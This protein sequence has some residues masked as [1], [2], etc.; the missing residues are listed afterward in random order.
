MVE[1]LR[2][3]AVLAGLAAVLGALF[4]TAQLALTFV[5]TALEIRKLEREAAPVAV[6]VIA[7]ATAEEIEKY[8]SLRGQIDD[9]QGRLQGVRRTAWKAGGVFS[10]GVFAL[11]LGVV[12]RL[13]HVSGIG[14]GDI[15]MSSPG[16]ATSGPSSDAS[17]ALPETIPPPTKAVPATAE[18]G[19]PTS[20][21]DSHRPDSHRPGTHLR[22]RG[23]VIL[24]EDGQGGGADVP[25]AVSRPCRQ[26]WRAC[27][28]EELRRAADFIERCYSSRCAPED[29]EVAAAIVARRRVA[30]AAPAAKPRKPSIEF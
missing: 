26:D 4:K 22:P 13:D 25:L 28:S 5:K 15:K 29:R 23:Q 21:G 2:I 6:A 19:G 24:D 30:P 10:V 16:P 20:A 11:G 17:V 9:L 12:L 27:S 14:S 8:A 18:H 3:G 7:L 1:V